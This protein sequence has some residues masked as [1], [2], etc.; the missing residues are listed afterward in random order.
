ML[1]VPV[2]VPVPVLAIVRRYIT[3]D[4]TVTRS[5]RPLR[6]GPVL[7]SAR[8]AAQCGPEG[9]PAGRSP[10]RPQTP[11]PHGCKAAATVSPWAGITRR[12]LGLPTQAKKMHF[13]SPTG[14]SDCSVPVRP[15]GQAVRCRRG[16]SVRHR[17]WAT[18]RASR[19]PLYG[20]ARATRAAHSSLG[21]LS[22][23]GGVCR[24]RR[25]LALKTLKYCRGL[26]T[27]RL[28][29]CPPP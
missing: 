15:L 7:R 24:C 22:R 23:P 11:V 13:F 18:A 19:D 3:M 8:L 29:R 1:H 16:C 4:R 17:V 9:L 10:Y 12:D 25:L 21:W 27:A 6:V 2:P 20:C 26:R 14:G 28:L 5:P